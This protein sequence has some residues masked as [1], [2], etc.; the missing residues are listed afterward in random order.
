MNIIFLSRRE[1]RARQFNLAHPLTLSLVAGLALA[2][3]GSAF[4]LGLQF[5]RGAHE[6]GLLSDTL[7]FGSLL[8]SRSTRSAN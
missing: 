4:A 8:P 2:V 6:R 1:A 3:L 7:S 5:G